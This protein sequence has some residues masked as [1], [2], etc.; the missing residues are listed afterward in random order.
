MNK[1]IKKYIKEY[2][3]SNIFAMLKNN[4][5]A[6]ALCESDFTGKTVLITGATAGIGY[7]T[8]R[9]YASKGANLICINRNIQKSEALKQ[10]IEQDF[11]VTC[12]YLTADLSS[13]EDTH[14][15]VDQLLALE[16]PIDVLIHNAGVYL[17]QRELTADGIEKVF[18][19]HYLS[20]FIINYRLKEK[21][22]EQGKGRILFVSSEGHRFAVW[23]LDLNDLNWEKRKYSGLQSY[24]AAK[25]A[26]LL[27]MLIFADYFKNSGVTINA[28]HPGAV[29]SNSGQDNGQ[30]YK[31]LKKHILEKTL[32][33]ANIS[34]EALYYLGVSPEV[35]HISGKF[36]N[37]TTLEDPTPPALD[38]EEARQLWDITLKMGKL[39]NNENK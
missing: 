1:K 24:G 30:T 4:R 14:K 27:T 8:A 36:F 35:E 10:E 23:G 19:V 33:A 6:P 31:W 17:T 3:W 5:R 29:K 38:K 9:K 18:M 34:A 16:T 25:L 22:K 32:K 15:A 12:T 2:K 13:I 11:K 28:M 20:S 37:L 26:Q 39:S 7:V 21:L